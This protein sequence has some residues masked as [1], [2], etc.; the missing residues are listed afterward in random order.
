MNLREVAMRL[1][2][3]AFACALAVAAIPILAPSARAATECTAEVR[4][5]A[6]SD[7]T[8]SDSILKVFAVEVDTQEDCAKVYADLIVTERLFNG[9]EITSTHRGWRKVSSHTSTY[10]VNYRIAGDSTVT[11][12]KFKVA[13][14][15]VCGTE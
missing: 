13:R 14:C 9:E 5:T 15:V 8:F 4:A 10:K 2:Q 7:Q 11:D 12:W 1:F 6:K 3:K